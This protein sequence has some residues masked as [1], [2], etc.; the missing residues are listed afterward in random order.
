MILGWR[1]KVL[2][3]YRGGSETNTAQVMTVHASQGRTLEAPVL[4]IVDFR[5]ANV[6]LLYTALTRIRSLDQ[7]RLYTDA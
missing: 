5:R 3:N 4:H 2:K 6:R 1:H 7:L